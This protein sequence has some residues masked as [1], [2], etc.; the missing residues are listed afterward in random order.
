MGALLQFVDLSNSHLSGAIAT[1]PKSDLDFD[2]DWEVDP[3]DIT[4]Q[5]KLGLFQGQ[6]HISPT[7]YHP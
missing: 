5:D 1:F 7:L 3:R 2:P 6:L 4:L